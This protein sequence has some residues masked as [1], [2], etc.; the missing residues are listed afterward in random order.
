MTSHTP[1][2]NRGRPLP[3]TTSMKFPVGVGAS[4]RNLRLIQHWE[5]DPDMNHQGLRILAKIIARSILNK[6][7][8]PESK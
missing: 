7:A 3:A 2:T 5:N 6:H 1:P 8:N 4:K